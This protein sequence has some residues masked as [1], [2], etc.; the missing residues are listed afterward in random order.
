M[1]VNCIDRYTKSLLFSTT[2]FSLIPSQ[3]L[4]LLT[5]TV[6]I[7]LLYKISSST[8]R[9]CGCFVT[10]GLDERRREWEKRRT[11]YYRIIQ[12]N[13]NRGGG[14]CKVLRMSRAFAQ[15]PLTFRVVLW[16]IN[17]VGPL[18]YPLNE[19]LACK[20]REWRERCYINPKIFPL[21]GTPTTHPTTHPHSSTFIHTLNLHI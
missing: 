15:S 21:L 2:S 7:V 1:H 5:R 6:C 17:V 10:W 3:R 18:D 8:P 11:V 13:T 19:N 9:V 20:L 4:V 14:I 16:I 12:Y